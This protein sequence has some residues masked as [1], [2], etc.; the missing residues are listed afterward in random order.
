MRKGK[1]DVSIVNLETGKEYMNLST[2]Q[3]ELGVAR[4][5]PTEKY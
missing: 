5:Y 2:S 1:L 3:R 4:L